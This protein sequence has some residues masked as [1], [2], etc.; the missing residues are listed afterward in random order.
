MALLDRVAQERL[1][2]ETSAGAVQLPGRYLD[3]SIAV[4]AFRVDGDAAAGLVGHLDVRPVRLGGAALAVVAFADYRRTSVGPYRE[5]G[6][7]VLAEPIE[8]RRLPL[9][10]QL[11]APV[12]HRTVGLAVVDLPVTTAPADASGR[13]LFGYPKFVTEVAI[14]FGDGRFLGEVHDPD[15]APVCAL[16]GR[17]GRSV[18]VPGRDLLTYTRHRGRRWR[19]ELTTAGSFALHPRPRLRLRLG[20]SRHPMRDHLAVLGLAEATPAVLVTAHDVRALLHP[21][22]PG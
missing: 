5:A 8:G 21:G 1:H 11:L 4:A 12:R 17:V 22:A 6:L 20:A 18:R 16:E 7:V 9:P 3:T 19:T 10:V 2:V 15:G 14:G 13:E